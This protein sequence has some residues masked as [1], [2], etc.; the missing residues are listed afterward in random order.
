MGDERFFETG[1][2]YLDRGVEDCE[3][4]SEREVV[5]GLNCSKEL[6][7]NEAV[8]AAHPR[9]QAGLQNAWHGCSARRE[10]NGGRR[11]CGAGSWRVAFAAAACCFCAKR[12]VLVVSDLR[13]CLAFARGWHVGGLRGWGRS[14]LPARGWHVATLTGPGLLFC[15][16]GQLLA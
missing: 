15:A 5:C 8:F 11:A 6:G 4:E 16:S 1:A 12:F 7:P 2:G 10:N 13:A 14:R 3:A 9:S